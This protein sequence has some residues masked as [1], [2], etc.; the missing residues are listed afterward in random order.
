MV[1]QGDR[2]GKQEG[3]RKLVIIKHVTKST[4]YH[5]MHTH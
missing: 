5:V 3:E 2:G 4:D 1:E